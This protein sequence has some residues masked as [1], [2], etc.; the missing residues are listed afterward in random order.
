M[1]E[2]MKSD[3][4]QTSNNKSQIS[5]RPLSSSSSVPIPAAEI[6]RLAKDTFEKT[7]VYL[8]GQLEGIPD[9]THF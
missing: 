5:K 3:D 6:D 4:G 7:S 1:A 8:K 2:K 9:N